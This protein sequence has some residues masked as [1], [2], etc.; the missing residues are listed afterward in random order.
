MPSSA[1]ALRAPWALA[2]S[3]AR[4]QGSQRAV[5]TA[6]E[7]GESTTTVMNVNNKAGELRC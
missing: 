3:A 5:T 1:L 4:G 6:L 2:V 7:P